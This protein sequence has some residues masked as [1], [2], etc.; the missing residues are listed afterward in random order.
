MSTRR[1]SSGFSFLSLIPVNYFFLIFCLYST[2]IYLSEK[3]KQCKETCQKYDLICVTNI[4]S[5]DLINADFNCSGSNSS[6]TQW[7]NHYDPSYSTA[8]KRCFGFQGIPS[9][10][11]CYS[12]FSTP[13]GVNRLCKCMSSSKF[14]N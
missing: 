4:T 1:N 12:S 5:H 6:D 3:D 13:N 8:E 11:S 10:L 9:N 2:G 14:N 7:K